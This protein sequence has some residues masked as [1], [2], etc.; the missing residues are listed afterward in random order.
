MNK[1]GLTAMIL[2]TVLASNCIRIQHDIT[3][4]PV[5]VTVEITLKIDRE[6]QNF[7]ADIDRS[8]SQDSQKKEEQKTEGGKK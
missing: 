4:Q 8:A 2:A 5:H 1:F 7:F 3:V 6:L